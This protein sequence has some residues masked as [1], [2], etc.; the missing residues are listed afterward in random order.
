[1]IS[2]LT[3]CTIINRTTTRIITCFTFIITFFIGIII[4]IIIGVIWFIFFFNTLTCLIIYKM[5]ISI[6]LNTIIIRISS[7]FFTFIT[8]A[9]TFSISICIIINIIVMFC[10]TFAYALFFFINCKMIYI[11]SARIFSTFITIMI[12]NISCL[13]TFTTTFITFFKSIIIFII[14]SITWFIFIWNTNCC[15]I[16]NPMIT[17]S[18]FS[19]I[20][21]GTITSS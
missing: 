9:M 3:T 17:C 16:I 7:C 10:F 5:I 1:M 6:A 21:I 12:C 19:T 18:T 11:I 8:I 2:C 4:F 20:M 15:L 13:R 14:I